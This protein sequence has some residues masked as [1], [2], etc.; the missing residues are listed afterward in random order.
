MKNLIAVSIILMSFNSMAACKINLDT[1]K[2]G[3]ST[4]YVNGVSVSAKVQA[5]LATQCE[6]IKRV[7]NQSEVTKMNLA[8]AKKRY[9]AL[10]AKSK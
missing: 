7:M 2:A 9:E 8:N 3:A 5:A 6:L 1:K 4:S 10:L